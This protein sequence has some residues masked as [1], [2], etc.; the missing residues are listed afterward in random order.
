LVVL[1]PGGLA[2]CA[3]AASIGSRLALARRFRQP[4]WSALLHPAGVVALLAIQWSAL[5]RAARGRPS[6]W[7]GRAYPRAG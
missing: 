3:L 1:R 2:L 6:V 4:I 5:I 7:R